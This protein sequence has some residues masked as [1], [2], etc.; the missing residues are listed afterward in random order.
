MLSILCIMNEDVDDGS[1]L[2]RGTKRLGKSLL[3]AF[4]R[5]PLPEEKEG[6]FSKPKPKRVSEPESKPGM[7]KKHPV[8]T[9]LGVIGAV[10]AAAALKKK[11]KKRQFGMG[12]Y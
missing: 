7:I 10:S 12:V 11:M 6:Y 5:D 3:G 8:L 4:G 2:F 1:I 9:G